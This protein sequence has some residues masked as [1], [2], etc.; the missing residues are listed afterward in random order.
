MR[1]L[2]PQQLRGDIVFDTEDTGPTPH[3]TVLPYLMISGVTARGEAMSSGTVKVLT[4]E[5]S[6]GH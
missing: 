4:P 3:G 5:G 6:V 1:M 2:R